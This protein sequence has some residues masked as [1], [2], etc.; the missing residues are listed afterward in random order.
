MPGDPARETYT[1]GYSNEA[2][3][4][5]GSRTAAVDASF[6]VPHLSPGMAVLDCGCGPGLITVDLAEIV[7]PG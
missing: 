2:L 1:H 3:Q 7:A 5:F 6:L 4:L